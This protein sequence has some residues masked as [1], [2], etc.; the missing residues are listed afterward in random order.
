MVR[1]LSG[2]MD[3]ARENAMA[4]SIVELPDLSA[5]PREAGRISC[6]GLILTG[7]GRPPDARIADMFHPIPCVWVGG[8]PAP[9]PV[10]DHVVVDNSAAGVIA[11]EYLMERGCRRPA[12]VD[13]APLNGGFRERERSFRARLIQSGTHCSLFV[14]PPRHGEQEAALWTMPRLRAELSILL[15]RMLGERRRPDGLFLPTDQQCAVLHA[16]IRERGAEPGKGLVTVSCNNDTHWLANLQ[17]RPATID[18]CPA[19]VGRETV[20][21]LVWRIA[22]PRAWPVTSIVAPRLV[23]GEQN[24]RSRS[25]S[26]GAHSI[27]LS[28]MT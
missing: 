7:T 2:I 8:M 25:G 15:D 19:E 16:L 10:A 22:H 21:R 17:P 13:H 5:L 26:A 24:T 20:R 14:S 4:T 28:G 18:L 9:S 6:D 3:G 12:F 11:A 27:R 23:A 1:M